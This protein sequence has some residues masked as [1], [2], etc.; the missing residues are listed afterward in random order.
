VESE[1]SEGDRSM[2]LSMSS[3][4]AS[5]TRENRPPGLSASAS[6][7]DGSKESKPS[8]TLGLGPVVTAASGVATPAE[9]GGEASGGVCA[10]AV[11]LWRTGAA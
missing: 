10:A 4:D 5:E 3:S 11:F 6:Q 7:K 2:M 8:P 9:E 1:T